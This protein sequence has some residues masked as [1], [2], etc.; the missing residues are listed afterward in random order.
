MKKLCLSIL[1]IFV[2]TFAASAFKGLLACCLVQGALGSLL[3]A[4][5]DPFVQQ[6]SSA[7]INQRVS[8]AENLG[9]LRAYSAAE[10][11][12]QLLQDESVEARR[13]AAVSLAWCGGR[14]QVDALLQALDD[15][16]WSVR[17]GAWVSLTNLTGMEFPYE[18]HAKAATRAEQISAWRLWWQRASLEEI[19]AELNLQRYIPQLDLAAGCAVTASS[20]YKGPPEVLTSAGREGFWQTKGVPFPQHCT[21]DLGVVQKVGALVVTQYG[22]GYCMTDYAIEVSLDGETF[23]EIKRGNGLTEPDLAVSFPQVE[24]RFVRVV[25]YANEIALYPTTFYQIAVFQQAFKESSGGSQHLLCERKMRALGA[26]GCQVGGASIAAI[27][28][29][30]AIKGSASAEEKWMAQAGIRALGRLA[31]PET[32]ATLVELLDQ[33]RWARY[34]ADALGDFGGAESLS[35]LLSAYPD[36]AIQHRDKTPKKVPADDRPGLEPVDRM[37]EAPYSIA[38]A[39]SR[40][41]FDDKESQEK[42]LAL[43]PLLVMN[44]ANDFDGAMLY[45]EQA[46][47][48]IN[49]YLLE[50][51]GACDD[52]CELAL[53]SLGLSASGQHH[54]TL[55]EEAQKKLRDFATKPPGGTSFA[56]TWLTALCR[57]QKYA[58]RLLALLE[59]ANGWVRIN[60][61]K[62]L[63]FMGDT[64]ALVPIEALL[65]A[66]QPE[67]EHGWCTDFLFNDPK[68][69]G[70]DE[71][72]APSPCWREAFTRALG[73]LGTE[74]QVPLLVKLLNDER[75]VL[76]VRYAAALALDRIN[77]ADALAALRTTAT[78]HPFHSIK[79]IAREALWRHGVGWQ[80]TSAPIVAGV[81]PGSGKPAAAAPGDFESLVFIKGSNNMPNDFQIDIW[82]QN[83]S[84]TDSGPTYRPGDNLYLLQPAAPDGKVTALTAFD[85]GYVADCEVSWE[86]SHVIF[87]RRA[88]GDPWWHIWELELASG[89]LRQLTSGPYH[90]VQPNYLADGRIVFSS[91]RIGTRDEYHGYPATGLTVMN[92]DGTGIQCVGFNLG[93]DN[94]PVMMDDGRVLFS[95]LDLFYSRLKTEIT[96]QA[97][98][99]DG[100]M[101]V[102]LY[103]P[104]KRD[105]WA[106]I[107]RESGEGWWGEVP[108]RHRVLRL[109]QPH[110]L[111]AQQVIVATTGGA[112][113][114]GPGRMTERILP[115]FNNM[116]VTTLFPLDED[117]ILCAA[118]TRTFK[119]SEVD[120]GL[121]IMDA[122]SGALTLVYNDPLTADYEARPVMRRVPPRILP[123]TITP[124]SF[125]ARLMCN[126]V[127]MTQEVSTRQRGKLLRIVEGQ[128][129]PSRHHTHTSQSG[130]A[131]KN[132]VGTQARVLGTVPLGA[133]GSFYVEVPADRLLHCQ[134]LDSDRRVV[135]NQ[136][137]WMYARP[138]ETRS[139]VGCHEM[140]DTAGSGVSHEL[141]T[142]CSAAYPPVKCLPT[143]GEFSYRAKTWNKGT[144]TDEM[145][146]RTR[147]VNAIS[148]PGRL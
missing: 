73:A 51:A 115:R 4:T 138:G 46:F 84:T 123:N 79:L 37:Y 109:T 82:R 8:A 74:Q 128:P 145:E 112:A 58:P 30:T 83:Y 135:G 93:R 32:L 45:Q 1:S 143:G 94:E 111:N 39:L 12:V 65:A 31:V 68:R 26:L 36:Y 47:H 43:V 126:S 9:F 131:W 29:A 2:T 25:A 49:R 80:S 110:P 144:L 116:A 119:R 146:E 108:P 142:P 121:Y 125:T 3:D 113:V 6:L 76:E 98:R 87:A 28:K 71:Y 23:R 34:A 55:S 133:D 27:V 57:D 130:E 106:K 44:M 124:E 75:N 95:R 69:V 24:T 72:N 67:A 105:L 137:I 104:E 102:V 5:V 66:S 101:N 18:A 33:P 15:S 103:G 35:A 88:K 53:V 129:I 99:P 97:V 107:S 38:Q 42:L 19:P 54:Y 89:E 22:K 81:N 59:H 91:S 100:T 148:F 40:F 86:G 21:V 118:T 20:T 78:E 13:A 96:V 85:G 62:T 10:S 127:R 120:L 41:S 60:G 140:P 48:Q 77:G 139:C 63:M 16:D 64:S 52:L 122:Q 90:D 14:N 147:T 17:Q 50:Q 56:A 141:A 132:H 92:R 136:L 7:D 117:R 114:V 70:Q 11:L 134:V 61:A